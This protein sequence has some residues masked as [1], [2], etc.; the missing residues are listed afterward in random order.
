MATSTRFSD[1]NA[2]YMANHADLL[3]VAVPD[4]PPR[5]R[6]LKRQTNDWIS[7][8]GDYPAACAEIINGNIHSSVGRTGKY[9]TRHVLQLPVDSNN[10]LL[11]PTN[12]EIAAVQRDVRDKVQLIYTQLEIFADNGFF[13]MKKTTGGAEI[14]F[15]GETVI[16]HFR[17]CQETSMFHT[18]VSKRSRMMR[19]LV[20]PDMDNISTLMYCLRM[21]FVTPGIFI[22]FDFDLTCED[23]QVASVVTFELSIVPPP[24]EEPEWLNDTNA[25]WPAE[26]ITSDW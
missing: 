8:F 2:P 3:A 21:I 4:E 22:S 7:F 16:F 5:P 24:E 13:T 9:I 23:I 18:L 20:Y 14:D 19:D 6:P 15:Q 25:D 11:H 12:Q 1:Y 17:L 26:A 10:L